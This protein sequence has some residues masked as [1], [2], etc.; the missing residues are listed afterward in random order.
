MSAIC[1]VASFYLNGSIY[2]ILGFFLLFIYIV[3]ASISDTI[4][5]LNRSTRN[6][7]AFKAT[8]QRVNTK[9]TKYLAKKS[10]NFSILFYIVYTDIRLYYNGIYAIRIVS[11]LK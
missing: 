7:N 11:F 2:F 6:K 8:A 3:L 10:G 9:E 4:D 1:F 5:T